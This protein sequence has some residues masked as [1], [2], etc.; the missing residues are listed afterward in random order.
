[1]AKAEKI[2]VSRLQVALDQLKE[3]RN[4]NSNLR[5]SFFKAQ[6]VNDDNVRKFKAADDKSARV[7]RELSDKLLVV[8]TQIQQLAGSF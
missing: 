6:Q 5:E 2:C 1:M 4:E 8:K 7:I 3:S